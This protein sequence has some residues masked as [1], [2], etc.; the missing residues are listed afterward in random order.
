V[1]GKVSDCI[2]NSYSELTSDLTTISSIMDQAKK[3]EVCA[4]CNDMRRFEKMAEE[5]RRRKDEQKIDFIIK[6][7]E[8]IAVAPEKRDKHSQI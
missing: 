3:Q 8:R 2:L 4:M 6:E 5:R 7:P 1:A